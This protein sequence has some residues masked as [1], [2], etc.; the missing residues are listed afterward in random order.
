MDCKPQQLILSNSEN[1]I[2]NHWGHRVSNWINSVKLCLIWHWLVLDRP[3]WGGGHQQRGFCSL[4]SS[5]DANFEHK[6]NHKWRWLEKSAAN[7]IIQEWL[8]YCAADFYPC[9]ATFIMCQWVRRP[10]CRRAD[11]PVLAG[12]ALDRRRHIWLMP[13]CGHCCQVQMYRG[14]LRSSCKQY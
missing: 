9:L 6:A 10:K 5:T 7:A 13:H 11:T 14:E 8:W 12:Q 1:Y 3:Q 4:L 2:Q